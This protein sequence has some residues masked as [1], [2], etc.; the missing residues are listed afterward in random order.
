MRIR[1]G[2]FN[3]DLAIRFGISAASASTIFRTWIDFLASEL[4]CCI[5]WPD[6]DQVKGNLPSG[7]R[8]PS[9]EKVRCIIDCTEVYI[10]RPRNLNL[11]ALTWS[12][13]KSHNTIKFLIGI[14]PNGMISFLSDVWCG[15]ASDKHLVQESGLLD[16]LEYEDYIMA[17]RG[18]PINEELLLKHCTLVIPPGKQGKEQMT[19]DEVK[20][21]KEVANLRIHVERAIRRI[22]SFQILKGVRPWACIPLADSIVTVC[23]ALCNFLDPLAV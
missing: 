18:F 9:Y 4:S 23:A 17:D 14:T 15:R 8:Q 5:W 19:R 7:F 13:Y 22:K 11:Q 10:E 3:E 12:S 16:K 1:L 6:K 21:T 20:Q 2:A